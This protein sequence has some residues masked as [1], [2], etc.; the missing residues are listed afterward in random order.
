[1]QRGRRWAASLVLE[2]FAAGPRPADRIRCCSFADARRHHTEHLASL[3]A[4]AS[5]I[6]H[7]GL[8]DV[9]YQ[10]DRSPNM[11]HR[12]RLLVEKEESPPDE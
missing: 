12:Q 6:V 11:R 9:D 4:A 3:V 7:A 2:S 10:S 5:V 1:M 8:T